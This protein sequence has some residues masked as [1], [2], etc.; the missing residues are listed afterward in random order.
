MSLAKKGK[1]HSAE[2]NRKKGRKGEAHH[3]FNVPKT[4]EHKKKISET[5]KESAK[6]DRLGVPR[7]EE[8]KQTMTLAKQLESGKPVLYYNSI[9]GEKL[10]VYLSIGSA[11]NAAGCGGTRVRNH[12]RGNLEKPQELTWK[13]I[14]QE[15][16]F[17]I[18]EE[19]NK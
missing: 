6:L 8:H 11:A 18:K 17:K 19:L 3:D 13:F 15:E 2:H 9:T 7:T 1:K 12:C 4:E 14:T 10:G 5:M 16:Y